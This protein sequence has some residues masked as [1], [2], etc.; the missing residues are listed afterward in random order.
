MMDVVISVGVTL[1]SA[2]LLMWWKPEKLVDWLLYIIVKR[3]D[4][5]T[6]NFVTNT[7]GILWIKAG[8]V[9]LKKLQDSPEISGKVEVIDKTVEEIRDLLKKNMIL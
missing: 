1:L 3:L 9:A 2:F 7:Q 6:A 8:V 5:G 4:K